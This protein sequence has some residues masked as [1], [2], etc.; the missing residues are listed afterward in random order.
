MARRHPIDQIKTGSV[1]FS[2]IHSSGVATRILSY[3]DVIAGSIILNLQPVQTPFLTFE[4]SRTLI[5]VTPE[6]HED[7]MARVRAI[8]SRC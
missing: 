2:V 6:Q 8:Q 1:N 7:I 5:D 3:D 4:D